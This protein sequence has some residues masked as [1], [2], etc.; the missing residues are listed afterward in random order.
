EEAP[1]Q[2][3][4]G[5]GRPWQLLLL[6]AK[7]EAA[8]DAA[9]AR[10][11]AH[12]ASH[13]ELNPSDV[14]YTLQVGRRGLEFRRAVVCKGL[15]DAGRV[16]SGAEPGRVLTAFREEG[17]RDFVFMFPGLGGQYVNMAR[18]LYESE[19]TFKGEVDRCCEALLPLLGF[20]L[21]KEIYPE[22][23]AADPEAESAT[24]S[25][26]LRRM[27][28]RKPAAA[29]NGRIDETSF[30]Q[31]LL[32]VIEYA[33][34]RLWME[35]GIR[36]R[37]MVGYSL[38]EYVA[39][40]L[41]GVLSLEDALRL[42]AERA[43][44]IE[45]L[46][47]GALLAVGLPEEQVLPLL[48]PELS[49]MATNGPEQ[50][51]VSGPVEAVEA[52]RGRLD[53]AGTSYRALPA[54]HAFHS[55]MMEPLFD[56][57]VALT[58]SVTL[59]PPQIPYLS[60][61][62]GTWITPEEAT[63]PSY[64][65]RHMCQPVR[66]AEGIEE[67]LKDRRS[68]LLEVGAPSLSSIILQYP[69]APGAEPPTTVNLLRHSYE[70]Q[71]DLAHALQALGKLWLL[72]ARPDWAQFYARERRRRV[73]LP[74]YPFQRR[75]YWI[76]AQVDRQYV[77]QPTGDASQ[78][79]WLYVPSWRR[80]SVP[81]A[82][83]AAHTAD[84]RNDWWVLV[85]EGGLGGEL[86]D[87][88]EGRGRRVTRLHAGTGFART[89]PSSFTVDPTSPEDYAALVAEAGGPPRSVV[90]LWDL[91]GDAEES[92][93]ARDG[94]GG[95]GLLA[96][97]RAVQG[98]D[99]VEALPV[100]VVSDSAHEVTG[101]EEPRP[102][103]AS[104]LGAC[105]AASRE[106]SKLLI[107]NLDVT[108]S[109]RRP[110]ERKRL[111]GHLLGETT[112]GTAERVV[113]YRGG[114]RWVPTLAPASAN[115]AGGGE[116]ASEGARTYLLI[117]GP[118]ALGAD[119]FQ[120]L[121]HGARPRLVLVETADFPA[122]ELWDE[123][124]AN[125]AG[126]G[127]ISARIESIRELERR[128]DVFLLAAELSDGA[129]ARALSERVKESFGALDGVLYVLD[130]EPSTAAADGHAP[131]ASLRERVRGLVA[132][133][134]ALRDED[135]PCRLLISRTRTDAPLNAADA[136]LRFFADIFAG[137]SARNGH[138][139][140]TSVTWD[141][142]PAGGD[143]DRPAFALDRLL[144]LGSA[145]VVVSAEP[146]AEGW[147]KL[148]ALMDGSAPE[149]EQEP[150]TLYPRPTLRVAYVAPRTP[151]EQSV[152]QIWMELLGVEQVGA[153]DSFLALGGDSLLAVRLIS[154]L[155]DV[156]H[157]DIPLRLIFEASTVA[158]LAKAIEPQEAEPQEDE[159]ARLLGMLDQLSEE[160]A[161]QELLRRRQETGT[162]ATA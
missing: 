97:S 71:S 23:A 102:S 11:G 72:G 149:A 82:A 68:V 127:R 100:W 161:E 63:D 95:S 101:E 74:T 92:Q 12:L 31:P 41:A 81:D 13:P 69:S 80:T 156:F 145:Q 94:R 139:P 108:A 99:G 146:L 128:A 153:H 107:R 143:G 43:R 64:W 124:V 78:K 35:W 142:S 83:G 56:A 130:G 151:T 2:E 134:E 120:H 157:K 110:R 45:G 53:A 155:R 73:L 136:A 119:F 62:T 144:H 61:V 152:A 33:L 51:V 159:L 50:C 98:W 65:A 158:E 113:A 59:N 6:S 32:F 22:A 121:T 16:L 34:A 8:L 57:V 88:L 54:R 132:L 116:S 91:A 36:P 90:H 21:R 67:L 7:S 14:A 150:I 129:E 24:A 125:D 3:E 20:D 70:M 140:W 76:D 86:A 114:H 10:L 27:L 162:E 30:T 84:D 138:Q 5:E 148:G 17:E 49:L 131:E 48:G 77:G 104:L 29:G 112:N 28:G 111:V 109:L 133:D 26:D 122:R 25:V 46:P 118:G 160:D 44:M 42:V 123:W 1:P 137:D 85:D 117:N 38:G 96:L 47:A 15:E 135:I 9:T 60:N 89:G 93:A 79:E 141:V 75:R 66:F 19:P 40:C 147:N 55:K 52:L 154:R 126:A 115:G 87:A 39:A 18:G 105:A 4:S 103:Q 106:S 58:Q 37:A